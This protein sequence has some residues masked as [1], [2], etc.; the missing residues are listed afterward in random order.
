MRLAFYAEVAKDAG[1]EWSDFVALAADNVTE[2]ANDFV[3]TGCGWRDLDDL[4]DYL[5]QQHTL[6]DRSHLDAFEQVL[7]ATL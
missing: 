5:D 4:E 3:R 6:P 7:E 1:Y 2:T